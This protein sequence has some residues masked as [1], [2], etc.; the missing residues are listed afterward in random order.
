MACD[1]ARKAT[2]PSGVCGQAKTGLACGATQCAGDQQSGPQCTAAA[3]CTNAT[4]ACAPY[5]C[6]DA[7]V[8]ATSCA[9]DPDCSSTH[10]CSAGK[11]NPKLPVGQ[12]CAKGSQCQS[13]HCVDWV[14]CDAECGGNVQ[15]DCQGCSKAVGASADGTCS[16]LE[17]T[18]CLTGVCAAG[19]CVPKKPD[20]GPGQDAAGDAADALP[21][22]VLPEAMATEPKVEAGPGSDAPDAAA[23][24]GGPV[25]DADAGVGAA[26]G[27]GAPVD[28]VSTDQAGGCGCR[29]APAQPAANPFAV[30]ASVLAGALAARRRRRA[31]AD[32]RRS[33]S[34]GAEH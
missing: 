21:D 11:C 31:R 27:G 1:E 26:G 10:F 24:E 9:L 6:A 28:V 8:C 14:C 32:R 30:A 34:K 12:P 17:G 4:V 2:G 16:Q 29:S 19:Q 33:P 20:A 13:S 15:N 5:K 7:F 18:P 25:A 22:I 23:G 3:Q